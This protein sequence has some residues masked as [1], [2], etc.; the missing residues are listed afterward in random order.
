[1]G[2]CDL[3]PGIS[4]GTI[5]FITGIYERLILAISE[6]TPKNK[7]EFLKSIVKKDK[8]ARTR[9]LKKMDLKF[10]GILFGGIF[11]SIIIGSHAI[12]FLLENYY[13]FLLSFFVGL[14]LISS[15]II[16][17]SINTHSIQNIGLAL[18]GFLVGFSLLF[19]S[20]KEVV[21]PSLFY[22]LLGGFLAI[23]ALF[24]PGV[25]G[26]FV[27]LVMGL[28]EHIINSVKDLIHSW[29]TL[30]FF[31]IGA[32]LGV[33]I[34]SKLITYLFKK[35]KCKTLYVLLGIVLGSLIIPSVRI[36]ESI[37]EPSLNIFLGIFI[38]FTLGGT[39]GHYIEKLGNK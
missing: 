4:G 15:K 19:I 2:L 35:D 8:K 29:K 16:Y 3:V 11:I 13:M 17:K 25:S 34:I 14:I 7:I 32:I 6:I 28:Y 39:F 37:S 33:Q 36:I 31:G 5:A 18:V 30:L 23:F 27:L 10:L 12:S 9:I 20:P 24:L 38:C 21:D 22:I 1:M 26:S